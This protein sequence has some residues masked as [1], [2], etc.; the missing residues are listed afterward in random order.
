MESRGAWAGNM[1]NETLICPT[2]WYYWL[3]MTDGE[4]S[5]GYENTRLTDGAGLHRPVLAKI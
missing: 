4:V 1:W 2:G 3:P 5:H